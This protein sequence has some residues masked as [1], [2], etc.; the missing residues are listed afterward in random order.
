M[1]LFTPRSWLLVT[2]LLLG[3]TTSALAQPGQ[4]PVAPEV[5]APGHWTPFAP[6]NHEPD[7]RWFAPV[8][9]SEYGCDRPD[10]NEGFF[11]QYDRLIWAFTRP[12]KTDIG[13][14]AAERV[15]VL[16]I[17]SDEPPNGTSIV[18]INDADTKFIETEWVWGNRFEMGYVVDDHGWL[19]SGSHVHTHDRILAAND[20][21]IVFND[22][23]GVTFGFV[24]LNG[25]FYDDDL[26]SNDTFGR[27]I[28]KNGDGAAENV[29]L[30]PI[31]GIPNSF[32]ATDFEDQ[33]FHPVRF[34]Q[35]DV[36]NK[37]TM[38]SLELMK[39][40]RLPRMHYGGT[41]EWLGGVR[42]LNMTDQFDLIG[43]ESTDPA[44]PQAIGNIFD[45][46][47]VNSLI[48]NHIVG[49]QI[50]ARWARTRGRWTVS[51]EG[52]F[53]AGVNFQQACVE[54]SYATNEPNDFRQNFA[55]GVP[56]IVEASL[57]NLKA[58]W[59]DETEMDSEFAPMG[60][61]RFETQF[62]VTRYISL[63]MGYEGLVAGGT[64]RASRRIDWSLPTIGVL[65]GRK[66]EAFIVNG[67]N[68]GFEINR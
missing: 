10:A 41:W 64:G 17:A 13:S 33:T 31:T 15:L 32:G 24:D 8:D 61:L 53:T 3:S 21:Q 67:F 60:E 1:L 59:F 36:A 54:G 5:F 6:V 63:R 37:T 52:R 23:L 29:N 28:D 7:W 11:F 35:L 20:A 47:T 48:N 49:P 16:P 22:P 46:L 62:L 34:E 50:G 9:L 18:Y 26:N 51:A 58:R 42:Y 66:N 65:D 25:D 2:A 43:Q 4:S 30:P 57:P 45:V 27:P 39:I 38:F 19:F 56:A 68:F 44:A 12:K 14:E 55:T 40:W